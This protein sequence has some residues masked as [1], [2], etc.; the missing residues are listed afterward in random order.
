MD[1]GFERD[2]WHKTVRRDYL[3]HDLKTLRKAKFK[4]TA[5]LNEILCAGDCAMKYHD[6]GER[7]GELLRKQGF[8]VGDNPKL[9]Q[10]G[11]ML[12]V[13]LG[14]AMLA[15]VITVE[16]ARTKLGPTIFDRAKA[17]GDVE[18]Y[19]VAAA[20]YADTAQS[21][22]IDRLAWAATGE[23]EFAIPILMQQFR[24]E[25]L[26]L[27]DPFLTA[28]FKR[29]PEDATIAGMVCRLTSRADRLDTAAI[30]IALENAIKAEFSHFSLRDEDRT[31]VRFAPSAGSRLSEYF[32]LLREAIRR[33]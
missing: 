32:G 2:W 6:D 21:A 3:K 13:M 1:C 12:A 14:R 4:E 28:A 31:L 26:K 20:L 24:S 5:R 33:N 16:Q 10:S 8:L 30:A 11:A 15:N 18:S 22:E 27:D 19:R 7:I 9:P 29:F 23:V 17:T 25:K